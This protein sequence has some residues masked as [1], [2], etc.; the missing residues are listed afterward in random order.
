[1]RLLSMDVALSV[2]I[3]HTVE[4]VYNFGLKSTAIAV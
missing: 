2:T 1:M 4:C 3:H